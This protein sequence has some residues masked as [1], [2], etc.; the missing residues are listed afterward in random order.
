M[1]NTD[2]TTLT[3]NNSYTDECGFYSID[4]SKAG[5]E[6]CP[7]H[8]YKE[9]IRIYIFIFIKNRK[10]I[11][12]LIIIRMITGSLIHTMWCDQILSYGTQNILMEVYAYAFWVFQNNI[13]LICSV[14]WIHE[15]LFLI[16]STLTLFLTKLTT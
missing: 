16:L 8:T 9:H 5:C 12:I 3:P 2:H 15:I 7:F 10:E 13:L 1:K 4:V 14:N 6:R 11:N